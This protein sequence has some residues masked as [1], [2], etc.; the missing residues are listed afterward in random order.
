MGLFRGATVSFTAAQNFRG[1]AAFVIELSRRGHWQVVTSAYAAEEARRN[2]RRKYPEWDDRLTF[3]LDLI[4]THPTPRGDQCPLPLSSKGRPIFEAA[5]R[6]GATHLLTNDRVEFDRFMN[7][8]AQ[9]H[10]IE[11]QTVADFVVSVIARD[12]PARPRL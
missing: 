1:R 6:V 8:A 7:R 5:M 9:T 4:E 10:G 2:I 12:P 11:I 3:L